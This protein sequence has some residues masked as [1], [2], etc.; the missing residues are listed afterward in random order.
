MFF[1]QITLHSSRLEVLEAKF[2]SLSLTLAAQLKIM[3][4]I[5]AKCTEETGLKKIL[6][7]ILLV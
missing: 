1:N 6:T 4:A 7:V 2:D 5:S 3:N